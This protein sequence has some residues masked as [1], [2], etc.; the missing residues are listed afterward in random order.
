MLRNFSVSISISPHVCFILVLILMSLF[1]RYELGI[2]HANRTT[3]CLRNQ[4]RTKGEGCSTAN[5]LK[6]PNNFI[7][8]RPNAALLFWLFS[9]LRCGVPL[10]IV[11]LAIYKN[12]NIQKYM[13]IV[14]LAS[15]HLYGK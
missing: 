12:K 3:K 6:P 2:F 1:L 5:K 15:E 7:A 14:R 4:D 13:L 9:D 8:G 10:F 11:I